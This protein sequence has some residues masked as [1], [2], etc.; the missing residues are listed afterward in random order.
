MKTIHQSPLCQRL[1]HLQ[2]KQ[3]SAWY[4]KE[5]NGPPEH[6][7]IIHYIFVYPKLMPMLRFR[8]LIAYIYITFSKSDTL[9]IVIMYCVVASVIFLL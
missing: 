2:I 3:R 8:T 9:T 7:P 1:I 4:I 5:G 6:F